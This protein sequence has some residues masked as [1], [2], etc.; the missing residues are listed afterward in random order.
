MKHS[1]GMAHLLFEP[2][3]SKI[4]KIVNKLWRFKVENSQKS[5][6]STDWRFYICLRDMHMV[7]KQCWF[8][9]MHSYSLRCS[10]GS[11]HIH[12]HPDQPLEG[13]SQVSK[14]PAIYT[15]KSICLCLMH[16]NSATGGKNFYI[17]TML[18][19]LQKPCSYNDMHIHA[20]NFMQHIVTDI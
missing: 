16:L 7:L 19:Y 9:T 5:A 2:L 1:K 10:A 18:I 11:L 4:C 20:S 6:P 3:T 17:H 8:V 13:K 12:I 14:H 15:N